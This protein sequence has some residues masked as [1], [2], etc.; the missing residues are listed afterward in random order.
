MN[1]KKYSIS[2]LYCLGLLREGNGCY[3]ILDKRID[4]IYTD[5][6]EQYCYEHS[7]VWYDTLKK[8]INAYDKH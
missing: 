3:K 5:S 1:L 7:N 2:D 8:A 6:G 4:I